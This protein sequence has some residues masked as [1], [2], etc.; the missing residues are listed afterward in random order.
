MKLEI[1]EKKEVPL[2]SRVRIQAMVEFEKETPSREMLR[3]ELAKLSKVKDELVII[4]HVYMKFGKKEAKVI[5]H[6]YEKLEDLKRIEE[7][8]LVKKH[9]KEEKGE[10]K[11]AGAEAAPA[12]AEA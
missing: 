2:L 10:K 8:H 5:A 1:K 4:K 12:K 9:F 3:K 11:E 7:G 6:V